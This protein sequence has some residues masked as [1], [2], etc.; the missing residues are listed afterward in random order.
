MIEYKTVSL[1][2]Q[3][4]EALEKKI[5]DGT[6]QRGEAVS[7]KKLSE[8]LGVS[9]TPIREA[10]SR[11]MHDK[12]IRETPNGA[13]VVGITD[14]DIQD[15]F[16]VKRRIEVLATRWAAENIDE[17]GIKKLGA[18]V[19]EQEYYAQKGDAEKVRDLDTEFHD[20]IYKESGSPIMESILSPIHH[21]MHK[22]RKAS[23]EQAH[24]ILDSVAEHRAIYEAIASHDGDK[25]DTLMLVHIEHAY[26]SMMEGSK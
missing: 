8:E 5:L 17:E 19:D 26:H 2:N 23:L 7:E 10:M 9:R 18:L 3:V 13:V 25:V 21:K 22:Y 6:Y 15:L 20:T 24:R 16:E 12:L 4:Y 1:A 14:K 11:L